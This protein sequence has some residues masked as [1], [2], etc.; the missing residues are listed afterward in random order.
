MSHCSH[1]LNRFSQPHFI[2]ED[3][4]LLNHHVL[5]AKFLITP[6]LYAKAIENKVELL[7]TV[8]NLF[9]DHAALTGLDCRLRT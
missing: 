5:G 1:R 8:G 4:F 3:C 2:T 7:N 6:Q 9:R